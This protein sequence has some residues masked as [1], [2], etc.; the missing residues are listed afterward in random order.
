MHQLIYYRVK[1]NRTGKSVKL[2]CKV[3]IV[4][5]LSKP[6][7]FIADKNK[8]LLV[9]G[10]SSSVF[11]QRLAKSGT[12]VQKVRSPEGYHKETILDKLKEEFGNRFTVTVVPTYGSSIGNRPVSK[13]TAGGRGASVK[14]AAPSKKRI[15]KKAAKK[16]SQE[17]FSN[18]S[19]SAEIFKDASVDFKGLGDAVDILEQKIEIEKEETFDTVEVLFATDRNKTDS[20]EPND[21]FGNTRNTSNKLEYGICKVSIPPEHK[22]GKIERPSWF[23]KLFF[24]DPENQLKHVVIYDLQT[25]TE[26]DF[27]SCLKT[28]ITSSTNKDA[29]IFIHGFRVS[30]QEAIRRTAQIAH[31]LSFKGAAIS[32]SWPSLAKLNGYMSDEDSIMWT[33]PHLKQLIKNVL[34]DTTLLKLHLIAHSMGNRALTNAIKELKTEGF[35]LEKINQ[36][37]LAAP[38]IDSNVFTDVIVPGIKGISKQITLYASSKD[39]ALKASR[40][41]RSGIIRAGE[42]GTNIVVVEGVST[43]D[44]SK[45]DTDF[46]GHGYFA[47]T[48]ALIN[49]IYLILEHSFIP[50]ERKLK[51]KNLPSKGFYWLFP[52]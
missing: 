38:D 29:F 16:K 4:D 13:K 36:I 27:K 17:K 28:K 48:K 15:V 37:I 45:V 43:V 23:D 10:R 18:F 35:N 21:V 41:F 12:L 1:N 42:S 32:Y 52:A 40:K 11:G 20:L 26:L 5:S 33:V 31:D 2:E 46:F 8:L 25:K 22:D 9:L 19:G 14:K 6:V 30:F 50:S 3:E 44:A 39:K 49:D 51:Q 24:S 7:T 34:S 47:E